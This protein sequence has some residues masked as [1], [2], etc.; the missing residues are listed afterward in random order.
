VHVPAGGEVDPR[1]RVVIVV[2]TKR[3]VLENGCIELEIP[4]AMLGRTP[5]PLGGCIEF[6]SAQTSPQAEQGRH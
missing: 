2:F 4:E 1:A 3:K 6:V 5:K